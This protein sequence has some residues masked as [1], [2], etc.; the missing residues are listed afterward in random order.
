M[1]EEPEP[2]LSGRG[3]ERL[4]AG[5]SSCAEKSAASDMRCL[6]GLSARYTSTRTACSSGPACSL[7]AADCRKLRASSDYQTGLNAPD[8]TIPRADRSTASSS[9]ETDNLRVLLVDDH[10][11]IRD[12]ITTLF[13]GTMDLS[14][15]GQTGSTDRA[16][17]M[18]ESLAP[19]V[20]I[21]DIS[22]DD[23]Y[24][25]DLVRN[26]NAQHPETKVIVFSMFDENVFAERALRAGALGFVEKS[27]P[28]DQLI[29]AVRAAQRGDV[30]LSAHITSRLLGRVA[31]GPNAGPRFPIDTLTDREL[32][33]FQMLGEGYSVNDIEDRLNLSRKTVETYRRRA[34]EKLGFDSVSELLQYAVMWTCAS[35]TRGGN[36]QFPAPPAAKNS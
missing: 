34:K 5:G 27:E 8:M 20:A 19:D 9:P 32:A 24:G 22:L 10:P 18:V 35:A 7:W 12:A 11:A 16:F 28:T 33:V 2:R 21:V 4:D 31:Q 25:L 6:I 14:V 36:D 26:I 17:R 23:G 3:R 13:E 1:S 15:C 30:H 29:K